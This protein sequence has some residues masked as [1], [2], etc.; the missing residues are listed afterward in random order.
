MIAVAVV[1]AVV[2]VAAVVVHV[3]VVERRLIVAAV[4]VQRALTCVRKTVTSLSQSAQKNKQTNK[5]NSLFGPTFRLSF[6]FSFSFSL[7]RFLHPM[8]RSL[9]QSQRLF[10]RKEIPVAFGW[11]QAQNPLVLK[12]QKVERSGNLFIGLFTV[13]LSVRL[14]L[15]KSRLSAYRNFKLVV[16]IS[17]AIFCFISGLFSHIENGRETAN[18]AHKP[19]KS[20][21]SS[22]RKLVQQQ[23][24][25]NSKPKFFSIDQGLSEKLLACL[26]RRFFLGRSSINRFISGSEFVDLP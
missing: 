25:K 22:G 21:G 4:V 9:R 18:P 16:F 7:F 2:A 15:L 24:M 26:C 11:N 23:N 17:K 19:R 1:V 8:Q 14:V 10:S 6:P 20:V 3:A 5:T 13:L 12:G